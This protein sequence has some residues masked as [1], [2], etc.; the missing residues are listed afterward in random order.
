MTQQKK[1]KGEN[2]RKKG[3]NIQG[4]PDNFLPYERVKDYPF[5]GTTSE[6]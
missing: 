2:T 3:N 4:V 6:T 1:K 5:I